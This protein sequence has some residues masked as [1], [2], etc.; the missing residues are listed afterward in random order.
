MSL[1]SDRASARPAG[2]R[3]HR[4]G[5]HLRGAGAVSRHTH[6]PHP[7]PQHRRQGTGSLPTPQVYPLK[8]TPHHHTHTSLAFS[9]TCPYPYLYPS[10]INHIT[11]TC[12]LFRLVLTLALSSCF[13]WSLV[14]GPSYR[15]P[16]SLT[17]LWPHPLDFST[18]ET[19]YVSGT[20]ED[21]TKPNS[22][23][24]LSIG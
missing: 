6:C 7:A 10:P 18:R 1:Q 15:A 2:R 16:T 23:R 5:G 11:R 20:P 13:P 3:L 12:P 4:Q 21:Y 24:I 19:R 17:S 9:L 8:P 14:P 22:T